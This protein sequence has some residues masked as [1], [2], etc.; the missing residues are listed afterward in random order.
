VEGPALVAQVVRPNR[1]HLEPVA[2]VVRPSLPH[3]E[4]VAQVVHPS[5]WHLAPVAQ[6]VRPSRR[7]PAPALLDWKALPEQVRQQE[8]EPSLLPVRHQQECQG[9]H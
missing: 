8:K 2:Q 3:P 4:L 9:C 6:V 7:H 5:H 1:P